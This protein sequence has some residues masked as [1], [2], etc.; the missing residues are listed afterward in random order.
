MIRNIIYAMIVKLTIS[1]NEFAHIN[2]LKNVYTNQYRYALSFSNQPLYR[3]FI[4][5][6]RTCTAITP[7]RKKFVPG[8]QKHMPALTL[9]WAQGRL[10]RQIPIAPGC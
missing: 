5:V 9:G 8:R 1:K 4:L 2:T 6:A 10:Q 3:K 7:S